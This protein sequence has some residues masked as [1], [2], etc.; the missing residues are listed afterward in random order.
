[1]AYRMKNLPTG[2]GTFASNDVLA[3][4][5]LS[6]SDALN[7][8]AE[9]GT[10]ANFTNVKLQHSMDGTTWTDVVTGVAVGSTASELLVNPGSGVTGAVGQSAILPLKPY[11][12][13]LATGA[14]TTTYCVI[15]TDR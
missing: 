1:M 2:V 15:A 5:S 9:L 13:I 11:A 14:I 12:R 4:F 6:K 7:F 3:T 8:R 10:T